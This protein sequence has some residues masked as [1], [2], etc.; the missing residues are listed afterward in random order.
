MPPRGCSFLIF[1]PWAGTLPV[2]NKGWLQSVQVT[3]STSTPFSSHSWLYTCIFIRHPWIWL[4]AITFEYSQICYG[5]DLGH[6]SISWDICSARISH[7]SWSPWFLLESTEGTDTANMQC[8]TSQG[9]YSAHT[10]KLSLFIYLMLVE[11]VHLE[12]FRGWTLADNNRQTGFYSSQ[13]E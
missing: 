3:P 2:A 10:N 1:M 5:W 7:P 4:P 12:N 13:S 6:I 8:N 11:L 9:R